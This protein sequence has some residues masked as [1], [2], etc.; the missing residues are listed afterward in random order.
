MP[1][2]AYERLLTVIASDAVRKNQPP[3]KLIMPFQTRPIIEDGTSS[4]QNRSHFVSRIR[5]AA[6]SRS[7]GCEINEW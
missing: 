4:C 5:R 1:G 3:P 2:T 6:S 7:C